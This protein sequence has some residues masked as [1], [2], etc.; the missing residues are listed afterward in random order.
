M[1]RIIEMESKGVEV[2]TKTVEGLENRQKVAHSQALGF[3]PLC[4]CV[5]LPI[6]TLSTVFSALCSSLL[7][8]NSKVLGVQGSSPLIFSTL[9][10]WSYYNAYVDSPSVDGC[11]VPT[12][13]TSRNIVMWGFP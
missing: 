9:I 11:D 1:D 12:S 8:P 10:C 13:K 4:S 5:L 6:L 2:S 7:S 3:P